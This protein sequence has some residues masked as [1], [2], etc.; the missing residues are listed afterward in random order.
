MHKYLWT[1]LK[2][3]LQYISSSAG[4]PFNWLFLP[5]GPGLGS[6][7]LSG[8]TSQ[9]RLPGTIW[10]LDLP[11]D[12]SNT[13][14]NNAEYF[15]RWS[16][17]LVEAVQSLDRVI[18]VAHSTGGMYALATA[19]LE[20][21]LNGLVLMDS[22]PDSSWQ[23]MFMDYVSEHPIDRLKELEQ[24]YIA[25]PNNDTL[26]KM[27]L[28][29]ISYSFLTDGLNNDLSFLDDLPYNHETCDWSAQNFDSTYKYKWIPEKIPTLIFAGD[30]DRI[31]PLTLFR[32]LNEF[33]HDN[34]LIKTISNSGHFPWIDNLDEVK[35]VFLEYCRM[36]HV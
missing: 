9:L 2:S 20:G 10:H 25:C 11:G 15:S 12:G 19:R 28:A 17:A 14:S 1:S 31:T 27:V 30:K 24:Q 23:Q 21:L 33:Q 6:E 3:R 22:A 7:S 18:L 26:K 29:S 16:D 4:E 35:S 32:D 13:T 34:I 5:G 36:L 8:L